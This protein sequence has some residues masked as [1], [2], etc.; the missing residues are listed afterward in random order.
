MEQF[1][2]SNPGL[3]SRLSKVIEFEDYSVDELTEIFRYDMKKRGYSLDVDEDKLK[4][5][6]AEKSAARDFGNARGVRN[7]CDQII[8]RHN[9]RL[10]SMDVSELTNEV[11]T[12]IT[13]SDLM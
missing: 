7:I 12:T 13:D 11:I 3:R 9:N 2:D 10:Y 4:Q 8:S 1:L 6:I 5:L